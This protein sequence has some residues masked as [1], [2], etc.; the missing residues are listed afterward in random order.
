MR[1]QRA[2]TITAI[3]WTALIGLFL[4]F[5]TTWGTLTANQGVVEQG[6]LVP[7][8]THSTRFAIQGPTS[9]LAIAFPMI[10]AAAPLFGGNSRRT[11]LFVSATFLVVFSIL[12][13][14][15]G[16]LLYIPAAFLLLLGAMRRSNA[17]TLPE[18]AA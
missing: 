14:S 1:V 10:L 13:T 8:A 4:L 12:A 6:K 9:L 15:S 17:S 3:V 18:Q 7:R 2:V 11:V 5:G 16:G